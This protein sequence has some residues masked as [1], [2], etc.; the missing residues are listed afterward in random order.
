MKTITVSVD[1]E[2]YRR[3][4]LRAAQRGTSVTALVGQYLTELAAS[5]C[6]FEQLKR[7]EQELRARIRGFNGGDRLSRDAV[8]ERDA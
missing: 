6:D 8:H 4:S 2:T 3:A 7:E 5:E 1:D